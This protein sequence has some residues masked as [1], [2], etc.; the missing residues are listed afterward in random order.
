MRQTFTK[1]ERLCSKIQ[2]DKLFESGTSF[3]V[4]PLRCLYIEQLFPQ[5]FPVQIVFSVPKKNFKRAVDRNKIK[6]Q[7]R[8]CYRKNK[9]QLY[10]T[11]QKANKQFAVVII[12][13]AK[14]QF[15]FSTLNDKIIA[16]IQRLNS[17]ITKLMAC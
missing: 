1:E 6:R 8:E 14:E 10:E 15:E 9:F 13:T 7:L 11:L 2:I 16:I 12:Y 17:D 5:K 3:S 4:Y